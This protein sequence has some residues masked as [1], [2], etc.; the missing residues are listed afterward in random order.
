MRT[1]SIKSVGSSLVI[2]GFDL[3]G[4]IIVME[5]MDLFSTIE[6]VLPSLFVAGDVSVGD[7]FEGAGFSFVIVGNNRIAYNEPA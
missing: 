7:T 1:F 6:E 2:T 3:S 5:G 4:N